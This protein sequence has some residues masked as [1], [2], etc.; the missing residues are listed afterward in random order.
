MVVAGLLAA[1]A[2]LV[3]LTRPSGEGVEVAVLDATGLS[4]TPVGEL[5]VRGAVM[6]VPDDLGDALLTLE[7]LRDLPDGM[8]LRHGLQAGDVVRPGDVVDGRSIGGGAMSIPIAPA[9]A[10]GG[11][12]ATGDT[13]DV[14]ADVDGVVEVV[15]AAAHVIS[16]A[17]S[18]SGLAGGGELSVT[19]AVDDA[20]ALALSRALRE[21]EIDLVR[22]GS[23]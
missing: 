15:V 10:V 20:D 17:P 22:K 8:V 13:V 5:L 3:V 12:I 16:V 2:N 19:L 23:R 9:R 21:S 1:L 4:G 18:T 14:L 7:A 6:A 11:L